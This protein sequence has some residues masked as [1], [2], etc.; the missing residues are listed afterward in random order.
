MSRILVAGA[1]GYLGRHLIAE[2]YR[3]GHRVRAIVRDRSRAEAA[4]SSG[5]PSLAGLV[6]EWAVGD[7][8]DP[9]FTRDVAAGVD[10]VVSALGVTRQKVDP[11][12]IDH[13]ANLELL[14]SV[15]AHGAGSFTYI[16]VL[17]G[18][19]CPA[20]LT[21]AKTAFARELAASD[22]TSRSGLTTRIINPPAY[23][24]DMLEIL[25]MARRGLV[26][27]FRPEVR[28]NPI[29]GADLASYTAD[30]IEHD[31]AGSWDVG[32]PETFRWG[33]LARLALDAAGRRGRVV[34]VPPAVLRPALWATALVSPRRAD[35]ARFTIWSM[36]H[37]CVAPPTGTHRLADFFAEHAE[38]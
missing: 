21:R 28:I 19:R 16:N 6:D 20:R 30:R 17:H 29:H 38:R 15:R 37:D 10:D 4:G 34:R 18:D 26:P 5:A 1:T 12:E 9:G 33:E 11:W 32:G 24:S 14:N 31:G 25:G 35:L 27:V 23:F 3:R 22:V 8:T 2:L 36:L 7:V 13:L